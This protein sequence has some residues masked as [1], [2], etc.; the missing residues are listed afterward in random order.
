MRTAIKI[1]GITC[2]EDAALAIKLGANALGFNFF[3]PSPRFIECA[4]ARDIIRRLPPLAATVGV[5][6]N[7]DDPA[8]VDAAARAAGVQ[9]IQLHGDESPDYC[10]R[11]ESWP[12]IKAVRVGPEWGDGR[13]PAYPVRA[14]LLDARDDQLFGGT[15]RTFDWSLARRVAPGMSIILAGGITPDN[16][17]EAI[18]RV[19]PYAID[20]CS[21]V[22]M[23]PGKKDP[24][25]MAALIREVFHESA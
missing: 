24:V 23:A 7:V 15:G 19:Q 3:R 12:L 25:K 4:A 11:L 5:F 22:E 8:D 17:A 14:L 6:V 21:G 13:L 18:R 20:V 16:A 1:C 10:R 2:Y 9:V